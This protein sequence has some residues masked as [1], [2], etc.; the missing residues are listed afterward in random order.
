MHA[1]SQ[2]LARVET[3]L[4]QRYWSYKT[5]GKIYRFGNEVYFNEI[6]AASKQPNGLCIWLDATGKDGAQSNL[7]Q[8]ST[9]YGSRRTGGLTETEGQLLLERFTIPWKR[10]L[11]TIFCIDPKWKWKCLNKKNCPTSTCKLYISYKKLYGHYVFIVLEPH[12]KHQ[13]IEI[14]D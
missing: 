13:F 2:N 12:K 8:P 10:I 1:Q 9:C 7:R 5:P 11:K 3:G 4:L 6:E 14:I